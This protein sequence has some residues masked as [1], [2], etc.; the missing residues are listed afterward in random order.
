MN[1]K[2]IREM[3]FPDNSTVYTVGERAPL[4]G[5]SP[6]D[7]GVLDGISVTPSDYVRPDELVYMDGLI[8][9]PPT[10]VDPGTTRKQARDKFGA[11]NLVVAGGL[12][13]ILSWHTSFGRGFDYPATLAQQVSAR[14]SGRSLPVVWNYPE[15]V[16]Q[17]IE[18]EEAK[19]PGKFERVHGYNLSNYLGMPHADVQKIGR[20]ESAKQGIGPLDWELLKRE[21]DGKDEQGN[22]AYAARPFFTT[23]FKVAEVPYTEGDDAFLAYLGPNVFSPGK[24]EWM[25]IGGRGGSTTAGNAVFRNQNYMTRKFGDKYE[26]HPI[27]GVGA[28]VEKLYSRFDERSF[29]PTKSG[30][31][32]AAQTRLIKGWPERMGGL[33]ALEFV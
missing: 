21:W 7:L 26:K 1:A 6:G 12:P 23:L 27:E 3:H 32:F 29:D 18:K 19:E 33:L 11:Y 4:A 2:S 10:V 25:V 16:K 28:L 8:G 14:E 17:R 5:I 22:T 15:A 31:V 24:V 20:G 13:N 30:V 9:L